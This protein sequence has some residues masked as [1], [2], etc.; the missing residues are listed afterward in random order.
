MVNP[1]VRWKMQ[2]AARITVRRKCC[3]HY[4]TATL[5]RQSHSRGRFS[6]VPSFGLGRV[7]MEWKSK[8]ERG[9]LRDRCVLCSQ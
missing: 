5:E 3:N 9:A 6:E 8:L 2:C 4:Y 7:A 1:R